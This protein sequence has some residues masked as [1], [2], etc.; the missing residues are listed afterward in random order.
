MKKRAVVILCLMALVLTFFTGAATKAEERVGESFPSRYD[1]REL[2]L[3]TEVKDQGK[4]GT[5]WAFAIASVLES[6]ALLKGYGKYDL[7][8]YQLAYMCMHA[9]PD[10]ALSAVGEGP[11]C[12]VDWFVGPYGAIMSS[13]L[14]KGCAIRLED[15]FPYSMIEEP[16]PDDGFSADGALY[17]DS[18]YTVLATDTNAMKE[19]ILENG[20]F[21][22]NICA[23]S[24]IDE[25]GKYCNWDTGAA[26]FPKFTEDY[27]HIDHFITVVGWDDNYS[28]DNFNTT[29]PGDGAWIVK[30][31]WGTAYD[32][33]I[34]IGNDKVTTVGDNGWFYLSYYDAAFNN[35]GC[36]TS[37]TVKN[38]RTF[39]RIYQY[40]G[41]AGLLFADNVTDAVI[42]F[43]AAEDASITSVRIKP[44]G[45]ITNINFFCSYWAFEETNAEIRVYKGAFDAAAAEDAEPIYSQEYKIVH[46]DYQTVEFDKAVGLTKGEKY[47]VRVT[48]NSPIPYALDGAQTLNYNYQNAVSG[49][50]GETYV[51]IAKSEEAGE[52]YD[53]VEIP[54]KPSCSACIKVLT[55]NGLPPASSDEEIS[56]TEAANG[57]TGEGSAS[58]D[59]SPFRFIPLV[60]FLGVCTTLAAL[61]VV[62]KKRSKQ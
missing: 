42:C 48:F 54:G 14:L 59:R 19:L 61:I 16:L 57:G 47:Y 7:S 22:M 5:C 40:D 3:A 15:E 32:E 53:A 23:L 20:A 49:D 52:W 17:V 46:P 30:N 45:K 56:T 21:Y 37:I 25:S 1:P 27:Q 13:S 29:P 58:S 39:D 6:N 51:R 60:G 2:G 12:S 26:Y 43:T 35:A 33:P 31:S 18:C 36:A 28:R 8:E 44:T 9:A 50:P 10:G 34:N 41:G 38:E 4:Y 11:E 55:K 62:N 24:W